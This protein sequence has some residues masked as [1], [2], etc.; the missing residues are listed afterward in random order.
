M[1]KVNVAEA[2]AQLS[3]LIEAALEGEEVVIAKRDVPLVRLSPVRQR[4]TKTRLGGRRGRGWIAADFDAPVED[5]AK[6]MK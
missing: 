4:A 5:F 3:R 6:Y 1:L 2:K